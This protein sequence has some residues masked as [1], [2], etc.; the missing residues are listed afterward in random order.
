MKE[1]FMLLP[2]YLITFGMQGLILFLTIEIFKRE[3]IRI[4][5]YPYPV[6]LR[7]N[8]TDVKVFREVFLFQEYK[9]PVAEPRVIVDGGANIGLTSIYFSIRYPGATIY[10][11]EPS[12]SNFASLKENT[13]S[14]DRIV[15]ILTGLWSSDGWLRITDEKEHAWA[16]TVTET[17][18]DDPKG[19]AA[20]TITTLLKRYELGTIDLLK[21]DVEG[22]ER[23]LF[24]KNHDWLSH[25]RW[26]AME[27][28]DWIQPDTSKTVF[29]TLSA[30]WF[31]TQVRGGILLFNNQKVAER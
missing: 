28:H 6:T 30:Y 29:S 21:L 1:R 19:F 26:I 12:E 11:V 15:P 9:L 18:A 5:R 31:T 24:R 20:T 25:T 8:S 2:R 23:E 7:R 3:R 10:A 4:P 17:T 13:Q 27:L 16:F 22:A 14:E